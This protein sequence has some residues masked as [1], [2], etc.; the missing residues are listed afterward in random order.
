M[1]LNEKKKSLS[2]LQVKG[3]NPAVKSRMYCHSCV[4]SSIVKTQ[5]WK[6]DDKLG[7]K[8]PVHGKDLDL[9]SMIQASKSSTDIASIAAR[10]QAG[11]LSVISMKR[12]LSPDTKNP[13]DVVD[14][15][16][17]P[18]NLNDAMNLQINAYNQFASLNPELRAAF[19]NDAD[20]FASAV[21]DGSY[22]AT[23]NEYFKSK[24]P[25]EPV[26]E[27]GDK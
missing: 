1:N 15:S 2:S 8:V 3:F 23:I 11:D 13:N 25:N 20:K 7:F 21:A 26:N 5:E 27:S 19:G 22:G 6:Y 17:L 12:P 10:A 9:Y 24:Q 18:N 4:G 14:L 16:Q